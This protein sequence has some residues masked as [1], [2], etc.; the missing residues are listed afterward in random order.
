MINFFGKIEPIE[1]S[2]IIVEN[3]KE[4]KFENR[5]DQ[6]MVFPMMPDTL[7]GI[8]KMIDLMVSDALV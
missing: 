7:E 1:I 3:K 2:N 6:C 8:N 4:I 5:N